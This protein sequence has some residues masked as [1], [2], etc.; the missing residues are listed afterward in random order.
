MCQLQSKNY[1]CMGD[2]LQFFLRDIIFLVLGRGNIGLRMVPK[3][4][5]C[6]YPTVT[7]NLTQPRAFVRS[8]GV[9]CPLPVPE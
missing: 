1:Q 9:S 6:W 4:L 7:M 2:K 5:R 3:D 8:H